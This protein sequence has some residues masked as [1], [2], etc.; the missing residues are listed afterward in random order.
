VKIVVD[1]ITSGTNLI[2]S[3]F[4]FMGLNFQKKNAF[5]KEDTLLLNRRKHFDYRDLSSRFLFVF[6]SLVA[7]SFC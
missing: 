1:C 3:I 7:S 2:I 4:L 5:L 6:S